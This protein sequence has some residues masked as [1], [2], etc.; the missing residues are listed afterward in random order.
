MKNLTRVLLEKRIIG[1][2]SVFIL[3]KILKEQE[4]LEE[5]EKE[6]E[7]EGLKKK[8]NLSLI[9]NRIN[10]YYRLELDQIDEVLWLERKLALRDKK[11]SANKIA[12]FM[13]WDYEINMIQLLPIEKKLL[14]LIITLII[15]QN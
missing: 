6:E 13:L 10:F 12:R 8:L 4:K 2:E 5:T 7:Q 1:Q 11:I 15:I 3:N 9:I 14:K